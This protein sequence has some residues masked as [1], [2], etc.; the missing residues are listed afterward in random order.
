MAVPHAREALRPLHQLALFH[1]ERIDWEERPLPFLL[2]R[3]AGLV[4][5]SRALI[6]APNLLHCERDAPHKHVRV[7]GAGADDL[8]KGCVCVCGERG[9]SARTHS[10]SDSA[11]AAPV[12]VLK[13]GSIF[14]SSWLTRHRLDLQNLTS[15]PSMSKVHWMESEAL[16]SDAARRMLP[17]ACSSRVGPSPSACISATRVHSA[18]DAWRVI[19]STTAPAQLR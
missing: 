17:M 8:C 3:L 4:L 13:P 18:G 6:L 19:F 2:R 10:G 11:F 15:S 14:C 16:G 5:I 7:C 1:G 12:N 9:R